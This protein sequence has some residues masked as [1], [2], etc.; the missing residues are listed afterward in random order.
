MKGHA[1]P[2]KAESDSHVFADLSEKTTENIMLLIIVTSTA[3]FA[4]LAYL[5]YAYFTTETNDLTIVTYAFA[6]T[7]HGRFFPLCYTAGTLFGNHPNFVYLMLFPIYALVPT[8]PFL[9]FLQSLFIS[10]SAWPLY[11][12]AR[13]KLGDNLA[14]IGVATAYL[15][16]P[17]VASQHLNQMHDDQFANISILFAALFFEREQFRNMS[18]ALVM[19]ALTKEVVALTVAMFGVWAWLNR[20][21]GKWVLFP[22]ALGFGWFFIGVK[23]MLAFLPGAGAALYTGTPYLDL[24]G[25][26]P[27]EVLK[28]MLSRPGFVLQN[29]FSP[30][31]IRYLLKLLGPLALIL[32]FFTTAFVLSVP[33]LAINLIGTNSALIYIPWHYGV[34][35]GATLFVA[36]V[37][38]LPKVCAWLTR[39]FGPKRY[40]R[41]F[42]VVLIMAEILATRLWLDTSRF[43]PPPYWSSLRQAVAAVPN[44]ASVIC[45]TPMIAHFSNR[46]RINTA[47]SIFVANKTPEEL[48]RYDYVV[49]DGNW[50]AYEAIGQVPLVEALRSKPAYQ[51]V[52]MENNVA[53]LR[54]NR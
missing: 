15:I 40:A 36:T 30:E 44:D 1:A 43:H 41:G 54:R 47:Y 9:F 20:R 26:S 14:A 53:V 12:L 37:Y 49:L 5:Q 42:A 7:L 19:A 4:S 18:I 29:T 11:L 21:S 23:L 17:T 33:N 28:T 45:P 27:G 16:F 35:L 3:L 32:P 10:A 38:S 39:S 46:P 6:Q 31:K 52:F 8:V 24:Y 22:L 51:V 48:T 13:R 2:T 34:V 50:R 25:K